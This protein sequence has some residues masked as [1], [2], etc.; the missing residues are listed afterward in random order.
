MERIGS[1][2]RQAPR[3]LGV[4]EALNDKEQALYLAVI[5]EDEL[6]NTMNVVS[7]AGP[8]PPDTARA[9]RLKSLSAKLNVIAH[10]AAGSPDTELTLEEQQE[11]MP[12]MGKFQRGT[13]MIKNAE[14]FISDDDLET[15]VRVI[16]LHPGESDIAG[17]LAINDEKAKERVAR[18]LKA[19]AFKNPG[20]YATVVND[21]ATSRNFLKSDWDTLGK[22]FELTGKYGIDRG[23]V[24]QCIDRDDWKQLLEGAAGARMQ[25][26]PTFTGSLKAGINQLGFQHDLALLA[27]YVEKYR[28]YSGERLRVNAGISNALRSVFLQEGVAGTVLTQEALQ[29]N[30]PA[31]T[32]QAYDSLRK[33]QT[34]M[35]TLMGNPA[36]FSTALR[37]ELSADPLWAHHSDPAVSEQLA[38]NWL[39]GRYQGDMNAAS[40]ERGF[41]RALWGFLSSM[42][43]VAYTKEDIH[44][45]AAQ[46]RSL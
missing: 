31:E 42:A 13:E 1:A 4:R 35:N 40:T 33:A 8:V 3:A 36:A 44:K 22:M 9:D 17:I 30:A 11:L 14:Q 26:R 7:A 28:R 29:P 43:G 41:W 10:G 27:P 38:S 19:Y 39:E 18:A 21:L 34:R 12:I 5:A 32:Q 23:T 15:I 45:T 46:I 16:A 6:R 37:D 24:M 25:E 2:I 20:E